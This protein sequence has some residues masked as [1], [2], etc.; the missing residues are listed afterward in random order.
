MKPFRS[1]SAVE[2]LAAHLRTEIASGRLQGTMPGVIRLVKDLGVGTNTVLGAMAKLEKEGVIE[3]QGPRRGC[4]IASSVKGPGRSLRVR[5]L[6][7]NTGDETSRDVLNL[8]QHLHLAN[9]HP[10]Y[11]NRS[12]WSLGMN[13]KRVARFVEKNPA[14]AWVVIAGSK[15]I[16]EWFADQP[17]PCFALLGG[18]HGVNLAGTKPDKIAAQRTAVHRLVE[19]GHRRIIK[20][21]LH[22]RIHPVLGQMEQSFMEDLQSLGIPTGAYN[23]AAWGEH[24]AMF[25]ERLDA[26]FQHTP[27]TALFLDAVSLFHA[28]RDHLAR[29]GMI[30]PRDV[31]LVCDDPDASFQWM[32]PSVAHMDWSFEPLARRVLRWLENV[33]M[34][35]DDRRQ[36]LFTARFVEGGTIGPAPKSSS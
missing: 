30:A 18:F 3:S 34:G 16:L 17:F 33:A 4:R 15:E 29:K 6:L 19:L 11:A 25:Y 20:V 5:F 1:L 12:M 31:S 27:P 36:S 7:F 2:Q 14:D 13:A 10:E 9:H 24:P 28:A 23:L 32:Q 35:K 8:M 21:V 26:L 22:D